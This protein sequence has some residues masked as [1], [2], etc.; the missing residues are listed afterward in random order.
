MYK[1]IS[2]LLSV[3]IVAAGL[4][5][6]LTS[7]ASAATTTPTARFAHAA[8]KPRPCCQLRKSSRTRQT[9]LLCTPFR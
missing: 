9:E 1:R 8:V 3:V 4:P 5:L 6:G 7:A 2:R